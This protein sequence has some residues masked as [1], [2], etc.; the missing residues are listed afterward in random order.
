[1]ALCFKT[2]LF[3]GYLMSGSILAAFTC[4]LQA[5]AVDSADLLIL[6]VSPRVLCVNQQYVVVQAA[7]YGNA[8]LL[9]Y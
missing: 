7:L 4:S 1:M 2:A 6:A 3:S 5:K 9:K 8:G